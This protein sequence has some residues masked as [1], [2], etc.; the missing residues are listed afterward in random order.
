MDSLRYEILGPLR[1]AHVHGQ[2]LRASK[3]RQLLA[4]LLLHP[5]RFVSTE[6]IADALWEG[7]PPR[8]ATANIRTYVRA[9]RGVLQEAGLP[10]PID[11][12]AAG[13]SIEVGVDELDSSM[14][15][16]LIAEGG[17]LRDAGDKR[18]AMLVLSKAYGLWRGHPLDDLTIPSAWEGSIA[19]LDAQYRGLVD[20][21]LDLRLEHGDASGAA[22]LLS[23]RLTE[24]PYDEQLWRRLVDAL[25]AAGRTGEARAAYAKAVQTLADELDVKPGEELQAAGARAENGR[26]ANW[27]DPGIPAAARTPEREQPAEPTGPMAAPVLTEPQRPP[28]Q[29]PLDLAD[30]SGRRHNLEQ[31]R[32]LVCGRD[33]VRPP[34][35]VISGAPGTG[36]TSLAVRLGHLV[37]EYFPDGQIYL[38]MRGAT[39]PR[40]PG[41][42]LTDLLLS[43]NVPDFAIPAD[44]DRRSA[45]LRSELASRRVLIVLDDVAAAS[46][47][48]P[49]MPGTGASAVVITSRNR[50]MDLAGADSMPLDTFDDG[51]AAEL[52]R[53]V[54]G[55]GRVDSASSAAAE[56]LSACGNLPLAIRIVASRLA[57]RPDLSPTELARRL[58]DETHRLDELSIG[59]LAVRTSADLSYGSLSAEEAQLYRL[60]GHFAVGE[61]SARVL[62]TV[63]SPATVRRSLDRL[64]EVNLVQISSVDASGKARYR[65]HDLLRL[66]AI[67]AGDEE[68]KA[69][70]VKDLRTVL[71]SLL[72]KLRRASAALPFVYFGVLEHSGPL[73]LP[74]PA[75]FNDTDAIAWF[76]SERSTF[77]PAIRA[78]AQNGLHEYAW[79]IAA[80]WGPYLDMRA[81]FDDWN[82]SHQPGLVSAIA[83]GDRHGEAIM[84]RNLGQLAL[85]QDDWEPAWQH[86]SAAAEIF[87]EVGDRLG[88]GITA[89]GLGTWLRERD[90][91]DEALTQYELAVDAFVEVGDK[92]GEAVARSANASIWLR[93]NDTVTAGRFLAEAF[94]LGVRLG[95][96]HR[97]AKV[98]R[99]IAALR[100]QQGRHDQAVRQLRAALAI[101][102]GIGD[103]HCGAYTRAELG[104]ALIPLGEEAAARR[105]LM[106]AMEIGHRLGDRS[107]EGQAA[108]H[109]GQLY[110]STGNVEFAKRYL[111]RAARVW[112]LAGND[113][114]TAEARAELAALGTDRA[115]G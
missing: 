106:D 110:A 84:H 52:L 5:N 92:N 23:S 94:L 72:H 90:R 51:E 96:P 35:A 83:C 79:R 113:A 91:P 70:A 39:E 57:Q 107:V 80:A 49:L 11:T 89:I 28:S 102:K 95:D 73:D 22:V 19:R 78:A 88:T 12:S 21:L 9:L 56:I 62:E 115:V 27:P 109:L 97:Q 47:V 24:D 45:A 77:V 85:Y 26:S 46:Q 13:Y 34:I 25:L 38:D 69:Q 100:L 20:T 61:F 48:A 37:R 44:P 17:H 4:T 40:D 112:Q 114:K 74:D 10:A 59:E 58:R 30:F 111:N 54:A 16:A 53:R 105:M 63:A 14:F 43:L 7:N 32:D 76:D 98:R 99:R 1:L 68:Q 55:T 81:Y 65:V 87:A 86:L 67:G 2:P 8:S 15:E 71:D 3:P 66:H 29:L 42:A 41:G 60:I 101:F 33:P 93:R 104:H 103:D 75:P 108:H 36:K 6:L 50:L 64:I 31:L 82:E 18:Q